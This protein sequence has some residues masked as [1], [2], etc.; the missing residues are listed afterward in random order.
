M[1]GSSERVM[2]R[3]V[4]NRQGRRRGCFQQNQQDM[5]HPG[6]WR[7]RAGG[8]EVGRDVEHEAGMGLEGWA[9]TQRV[10]MS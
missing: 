6:A 10:Y 2:T 9:Q 4:F 1:L 7:V 5:H 8:G 3:Q